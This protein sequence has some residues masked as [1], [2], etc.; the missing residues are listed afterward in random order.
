VKLGQ[1]IET[2]GLPLEQILD[3]E[4]ELEVNL[5]LK[6][7]DSPVRFTGKARGSRIFSNSQGIIITFVGSG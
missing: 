7:D 2:W 1:I 4:V 6:V 3:A 5:P